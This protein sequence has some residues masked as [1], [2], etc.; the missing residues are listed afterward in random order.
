MSDYSDA[1]SEVKRAVQPDID[2]R[3]SY[4]DGQVPDPD[5][6]LDAIILASVKAAL[7][8]SG[9]S[10]QYGD[11]LIPT[12]GNGRRYRVSVAGALGSTEP[13]WPGYDYGSVVSGG[14]TLVEDGYF[15][16]SVY[17]VRKAIYAALDLKVQRSVNKDQYLQDSRGQAS[18][19]LY[20]NLVR[21]RDK[22]RPVGIA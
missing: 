6:D 14:A 19:F 22:Y 15:V 3:L 18:S 12:V 5:S 2:P 4:G 9:A 13:S 10:V 20:L 7:W 16:G 1:F 11:V 8:E 21:E 17:D